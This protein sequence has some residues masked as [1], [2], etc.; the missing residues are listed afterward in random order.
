MCSTIDGGAVDKPLVDEWH[1]GSQRGLPT[2]KQSASESRTDHPSSK[3]DRPKAVTA[4]DRNAWGLKKPRLEGPALKSLLNAS[5]ENIGPHMQHCYVVEDTRKWK[6]AVTREREGLREAASSCVEEH[7]HLITTETKRGADRVK[8]PLNDLATACINPTPVESI[9][10][11]STSK[12]EEHIMVVVDS[13]GGRRAN[14]ARFDRQYA[15]KCCCITL[16]DTGVVIKSKQRLEKGGKALTSRRH[17]NTRGVSDG[18]RIEVPGTSTIDGSAGYN[19]QCCLFVG[20]ELECMIGVRSNHR[21]TV[22]LGG[23]RH[24][25]EAGLE[26]RS[27]GPRVDQKRLDSSHLL[28][29]LTCF[30]PDALVA[31]MV[32]GITADE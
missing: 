21:P 19:S 32:N 30:R 9:E 6:N 28:T 23:R 13:T 11:H 27:V 4:Y 15:A 26:S 17:G 24:T 22:L 8:I 25:F 10:L 2:T 12:I 1:Q 16:G 20:P 7:E 31:H 5:Q 29:G 18:R 14:C 3:C